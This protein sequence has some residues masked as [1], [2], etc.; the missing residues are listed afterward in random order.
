MTQIDANDSKYMDFRI[1][2]PAD[3]TF[4]IIQ[5]LA[6]I[7]ECCL[8]GAS[9]TITIDVDGDGAG[10]IFIQPK[11]KELMPPWDFICEKMFQKIDSEQEKIE[12]SIG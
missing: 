11:D 8:N 5:L 12:F 3:Q 6:V 10:N 7:S 9:R 2:G 4:I 1:Q